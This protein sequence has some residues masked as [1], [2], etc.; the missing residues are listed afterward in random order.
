MTPCGNPSRYPSVTVAFTV[1]FVEGGSGVW[2]KAQE[3]QHLTKQL[4]TARWP[5]GGGNQSQVLS[6]FCCFFS[7]HI[8]KHSLNVHVAY[9]LHNI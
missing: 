7:K 3:Q 9:M 2:K 1:A 5:L 6:S 4:D 8:S